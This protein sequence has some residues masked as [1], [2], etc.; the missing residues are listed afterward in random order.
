MD[1]SEKSH[2]P[3][4]KTFTQ[5]GIT[6][7]KYRELERAYAKKQSANVVAK[8][9]N[10]HYRTAKKYIDKGDPRRGLPPIALTFARAQKKATEKVMRTWADAQAESIELIRAQKALL[11][12]ALNRLARDSSA[13][14]EFLRHAMKDPKN[15]A[16]TLSKVIRDEAFLFGEPDSRQAL[17]A[18][19]HRTADFRQRIIAELRRQPELVEH[20]C[21][22]EAAF[23]GHDEGEERDD[24]TDD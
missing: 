23:P 22:L 13:R 18:T 21:M 16:D 12:K 14:E 9:C 7:E 17:D 5:E 19:V 3:K 8:A 1:S 6:V 4:K 2:K 10:V 20:A 15:F 11:T 24:K